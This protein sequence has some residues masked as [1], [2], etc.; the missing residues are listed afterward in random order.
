MPLAHVADCEGQ[1]DCSAVP[2]VEGVGLGLKVPPAQVVQVRSAVAV[3][4][5]L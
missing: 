2:N 4:A 1:K 3:A 5:A